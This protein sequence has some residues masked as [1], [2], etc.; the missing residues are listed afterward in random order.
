V[1]EERLI[2]DSLARPSRRSAVAINGLECS[3]TCR[4]G[5][6]TGGRLIDVPLRGFTLLH[7]RSRRPSEFQWEPRSR[8]RRQGP[9]EAVAGLHFG[10]WHA[11]QP[12]PQASDNGLI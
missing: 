12:E 11:A 10:E 9:S 5:F 8:R 3:P 1:L 7:L 6:N 2:Y 4:E